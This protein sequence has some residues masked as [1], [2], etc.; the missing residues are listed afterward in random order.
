MESFTHYIEM[1]VILNEQNKGFYYNFWITNKFDL[2]NVIR[3]ALHI[4]IFVKLKPALNNVAMPVDSFL[5]TDA[6]SKLATS[7]M[8]SKCTPFLNIDV[9]KT[10]HGQHIAAIQWADLFVTARYVSIRIIVV[11]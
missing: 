3:N 8:Y 6:H 2:S 4:S 5:H 11:V 10:G 9:C 7:C 1:C